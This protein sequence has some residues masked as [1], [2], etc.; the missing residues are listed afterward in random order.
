LSPPRTVHV[1]DGVE[2]V[3]TGRL[4]R[5]FTAYARAAAA[6]GMWS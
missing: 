2:Q 5:D 1:A 3:S 6:A 4:P